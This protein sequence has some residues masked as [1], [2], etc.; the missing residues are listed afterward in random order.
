MPVRTGGLPAGSQAGEADAKD[1][2]TKH[3]KRQRM[4]LS[5]DAIFMA[6]IEADAGIMEIIGGRR[7]DIASAEPE[8]AFLKNTAVP[9]VVVNFD[10]FTSDTGT[11]DDPFDSGED[12]VNVSITVAANSPDELT[13]LASR[14]RRAVHRYLCDH[15]GEEGM[16]YSALPGSGQKFYDEW[17]PAFVIDL[18]WQCDVSFSLTSN[19]DEQDE[20]E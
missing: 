2:F 4:S 14:I 19:D 13:D 16:P 10:G 8:D 15:A 11:K 18:T 6:A 3:L 7:W 5:V 20:A 9:F 12:M 17:K 1:Y